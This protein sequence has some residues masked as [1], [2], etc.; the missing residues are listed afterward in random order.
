M[1][2]IIATLDFKTLEEVL[3]VIRHLTS[4]LSVSGINLMDQ[5]CPASEQLRDIEEQV[6][7]FI[8]YLD[9]SDSH[10]RNRLLLKFL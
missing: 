1:A 5:I 6:L 10:N 2:E 4:I 8:G 9:M 3:T 7:K